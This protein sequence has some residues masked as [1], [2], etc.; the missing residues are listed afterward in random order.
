MTSIFAPGILRGRRILI[1]GGGTGLGKSM[2]RRFLERGAGLVICGRRADVLAGT[3]AEFRA[4]LPQSD[5]AEK[6]CDLRDGGQHL[7]MSGAEDLLR[8]SDEDWAA[9][10]ATVAA[11]EAA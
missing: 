10:R 3:A 8:R 5:V 7:R 2:G 11:R 9:H 1:A 4:E 6:C